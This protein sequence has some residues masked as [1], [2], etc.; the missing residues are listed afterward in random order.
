M[1]HVGGRQDQGLALDRRDD[2]ATPLGRSPPDQHRRPI[3]PGVGRHRR[4]RRASS[5]PGPR[6]AR[7]R[8]HARFA[9]EPR[10]GFGCPA[11]TEGLAVERPS[12][13]PRRRRSAPT[14]HTRATTSPKPART[15]RRRSPPMID[16]RSLIF[17]RARSQ[18]SQRNPQG[19]SVGPPSARSFDAV[20]RARR[21]RDGT[22]TLPGHGVGPILG[23]PGPF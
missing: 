1:H 9:L 21:S 18:R 19:S 5:A 16:R 4:P 15:C 11:R 23:V 2:R 20:S 17:A 14:R 6:A 22:G 7:P 10:L 3:G 8:P 13:P 12:S